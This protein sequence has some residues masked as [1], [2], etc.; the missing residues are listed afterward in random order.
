[1]DKKKLGKL[2]QKKH[3]EV[4]L[5][6]EKGFERKTCPKCKGHFW[7]NSGKK[8]C[9]D[10]ACEG[11]YF[12][13]G[14]KRG[15]HD[16][17]EAIAKWRKYFD[18]ECGHA[19]IE[20]YPIVARWR[21]DMY[22]T[23][24]S[25]ACF[26][27][28]VTNGTVDPP[29][30]PLTI[31]Q[32]CARFIDVDNVG[33]TGRHHTMFVM[34]GQHS[35]DGYWMDEC[36]DYNFGYLTKVLGLKPEE[37]TYKEDIWAGGGNFGPCLESFS[38]GLE[39]VNSV[40]MQYEMLPNGKYQEMKRKVIDVG[41]GM[42][43]LS[44][45][46]QGAETTYDAVLPITKRIK[47]DKDLFRRYSQLAGLLN[48]DEV[49]S[50]DKARELLSKKME[51]DYSTLE[52][53]LAPLE[54]QF[55][56]YDHMRALVFA[57]SD[58]AIPSNVGG[59]Y[60]LRNI[61]RRAISLNTHYNLNLDLTGLGLNLINYYKKTYKNL[62]EAKEILPKVMEV[63]ERK[64]KDTITKGKKR[65]SDL[66]R[67][68]K[69]TEK[70]ML[71]LYDSEGV[72]PE[73]IEEVA[74]EMKKKV[75]I[76]GD[77][78][79]KITTLHDKRNRDFT[80]YERTDL[81]ETT[82][83]PDLEFDAEVVFRDGKK[84]ILDKTGFYPTSGGQIHDT[85]EIEGIKVKDVE[86]K[87]GTVIH[88]LEKPLKKKRVHAK[89]D[90]KRRDRIM[91]HHTA[92]HIMIDAARKVLG[93]HVWQA[94][95]EKTPE[96]GRL[97][98]THFDSLTKEEI[99]KIEDT[100]NNVIL[101]SQETEVEVL[102]R[103][104][105]E[106][107]YGFK[108]YQG[109]AIP[110]KKIRIVKVGDDIEACGGSH[111]HNTSEVG[112]VKITNSEKIQDGV[113]RI[114][115]VAGT[116]LLKH[117]REKEAVVEKLSETFSVPQAHLERTA[118]KIFS[119]WKSQ[120]KRIEKLQSGASVDLKTMKKKGVEITYAVSDFEFKALE[121]LSKKH[122]KGEKT[123]SVFASDK[124]AASFVVSSNS[125]ISAL[126]IAKKIGKKVKGSAGGDDSFARGGGK[127]KEKLKKAIEDVLSRL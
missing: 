116:E 92:T 74:R 23:I 118:K 100:A 66:I 55:A 77:F 103:K 45:F 121:S 28:W 1:M 37:I 102:D 18:K 98:F 61:L 64:Y 105:A 9:G 78:Y 58:G 70:K 99:Q 8:T 94:G 49:E 71:T 16:F 21:D 31:P 14:K 91:R 35:F 11:G 29:A 33:K 80:K 68:G 108:L 111:A 69:L 53:E 17:H 36:I 43:R 109:G 95:A 24:A 42:E 122:T 59:G 40:F 73:M 22:F 19:P 47:V 96:K 110:G 32:P 20:P 44:W 46:S 114:E 10:V 25:I 90:K 2:F 38:D 52:K 127:E 101:E 6:K 113:V 39:I 48:V 104:D 26:Q 84:I 81:P 83:I 56:V 13:I 7:T 60:N 112:L 125:K 79:L 27:P 120:K 67:G 119:E 62:P 82:R 93:P 97:D 88:T 50:I 89:V 106:K 126:D 75:K 123:L 87:G 34:G 72:T 65:L 12:F 76:P 57:L 5:F 117:I 54:A 86:L 51:V 63:E 107:K 4:R 85:G 15:N 124:E 115:Y 30:N 3:F 41:W